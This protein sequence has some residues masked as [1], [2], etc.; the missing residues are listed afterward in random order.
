MH[1]ISKSKKHELIKTLFANSPT[2]QKSSPLSKSIK[3]P[4]QIRKGPQILYMTPYNL[5]FSPVIF[6]FQ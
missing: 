1:D 6:S 5:R 2:F 3:L 4:A